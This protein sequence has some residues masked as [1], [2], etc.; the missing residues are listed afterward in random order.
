MKGVPHG[1]GFEA[2]C[3]HAS[4]LH[5]HRDSFRA[6]WGKQAFIQVAGGD[7]CELPGK[8]DGIPVGVAASAKRKFFERL[9]N[10]GLH[11][12]VSEADLV[13]IVSMEVEIST[14]LDVGEKATLTSI[15]NV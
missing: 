2:A 12:G 15:Q 5:R 14:S 8:I 4:K 6:A 11:A 9:E 10:R 13:N 7:L 1:N 3:C